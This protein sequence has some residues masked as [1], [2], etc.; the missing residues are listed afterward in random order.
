MDGKADFWDRSG[1]V[2]PVT[3]TA[4]SAENESAIWTFFK[5]VKTGLIDLADGFILL[6][7]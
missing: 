7:K 2:Q 6:F 4:T 5:D 3:S 1:R